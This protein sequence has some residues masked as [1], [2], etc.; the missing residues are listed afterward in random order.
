MLRIRSSE[1][2]E[3]EEEI[4]MSTQNGLLQEAKF[5]SVDHLV[6]PHTYDIQTDQFVRLGK[7][8]DNNVKLSESDL[9]YYK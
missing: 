6:Y 2:E 3:G 9:V 8:V 4:E 7:K 1:A 5:L